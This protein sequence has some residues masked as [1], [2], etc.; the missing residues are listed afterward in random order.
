MEFV[1]KFPDY[2]G[3]SIVNVDD[4]NDSNLLRGSAGF[5]FGWG[6]TNRIYREC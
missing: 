2:T 4:S 3:P 5:T 1:V 6:K